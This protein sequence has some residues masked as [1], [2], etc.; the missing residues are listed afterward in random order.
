MASTA[1][2]PG[3]PPEETTSADANDLRV[4]PSELLGV[5]TRIR[6][7]AAEAEAMARHPVALRDSIARLGSPEVIQAVAVFVNAWQS[8]LHGVVDDANRLA[9]A[10]TLAARDYDDVERMVDGLFPW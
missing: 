3:L 2:R 5:A 7:A 6:S 1:V 4:D 8:S 10:V 9:E